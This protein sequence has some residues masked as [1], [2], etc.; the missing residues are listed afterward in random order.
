MSFDTGGQ[1]RTRGKAAAKTF[2]QEKNQER[3]LRLRAQRE[4]ERAAWTAFTQRLRRA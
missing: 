2:A 1:W 3:A 4:R